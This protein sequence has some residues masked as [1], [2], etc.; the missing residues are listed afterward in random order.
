LGWCREGDFPG[1]GT[2]FTSVDVK[3]PS[4]E[5]LTVLEKTRE[6]PG[7]G[8]TAKSL[9]DVRAS[10][11]VEIVCHKDMHFGHRPSVISASR[12]FLHTLSL[13]G[14]NLMKFLL[15]LL[16]LIL[17]NNHAFLQVVVCIG[18]LLFAIYNIA[19]PYHSQA[20]VDFSFTILGT[21]LGRVLK[22]GDHD[23]CKARKRDKNRTT[24]L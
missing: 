19:T 3:I 14:T 20:A 18:L 12:I 8:S 10:S 11:L 5:P 24:R 4:T 22:N 21:L 15:H 17:S 7:N 2:N 9:G 6:N 23:D 13:A 16:Q 1:I